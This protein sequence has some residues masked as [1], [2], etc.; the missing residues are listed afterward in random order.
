MAKK[1]RVSAAEAEDVKDMSLEGYVDKI[2]TKRG[3]TGPSLFKELKLRVIQ[4]LTS[5]DSTYL[6]EMV[7]EVTT[8]F[9]E[10]IDSKLQQALRKAIEAELMKLLPKL[11]KAAVE[12]A[13]I[14]F[15]S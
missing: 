7:E 9:M 6:E 3:K 14:A 15:G 11:A 1:A 5:D 13:Y 4:E 8:D 12:D 10:N 2:L